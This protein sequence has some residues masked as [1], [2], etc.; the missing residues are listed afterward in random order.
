[1]LIYLNAVVLEV[2]ENDTV[3]NS[4]LLFAQLLN[5]LLKVGVKSQYLDDTW[6]SHG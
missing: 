6:Q 4:I 5:G 1:M 2:E 3:T